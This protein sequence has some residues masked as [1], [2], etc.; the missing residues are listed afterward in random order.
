MPSPGVAELNARARGVI[1]PAD[2]REKFGSGRITAPGQA[3]ML[4]RKEVAMARTGL[5]GQLHEHVASLR[6]YAL[7]LTRDAADAEDLVQDALTRAIA[8]ADTWE[9][10]SN[11]RVWL[12]R[13]LHNAH[14]SNLRKAKVRRNA[15]MEL[16]EPVV[17]ESQARRIEVQQVLAALEEIPEPQRRPIV[18]VAL[19]EMSYADAAKAL[20]IPIGTFMSR[21]GRGRQALR[22]AL[23]ECKTARLRLV[24]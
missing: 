7:V 9:P 13:I 12:F 19:E 2:L 6:R 21:L 5:A 1:P 14:I 3:Y 18:L 23:G 22:R 16:P 11:L 10:E 24:V 4:Q 20:G 8:A 15:R 17:E